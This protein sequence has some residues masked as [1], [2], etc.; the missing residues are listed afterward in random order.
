MSK[1][2]WS[3]VIVMILI[4]YLIFSQLFQ[5]IM[6]TVP[7][8]SVAT[9]TP[10][11]TF[12]PTQVAPPPTIPPAP[13]NTPIPA[14]PTATNTPVIMTEAQQQAATATRSAVET[15]QA[16]PPPPPTETPTPGRPMVTA[17]DTNVNLRAGPGTNY[18]KAGVLRQGESLEIVGRNADSSWWQVSAVDGFK[19]VAAGVTT[20]DN[21][22]SELPLV[23]APPPPATPTPVAPPTATPVPQ[24]Q[25]QYTVFNLFAADSDNPNQGLTRVK[26]VMTDAAGNGVNGISLRIRSGSFCAISSPTHDDGGAGRYDFVLD[27]RARDGSWDLDVVGPLDDWSDANSNKDRCRSLPSLSEKKTV[28]TTLNKSI[29]TL[30]WRKNW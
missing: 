1:R 29:V 23:D 11:A 19:W 6:D 20:A 18:P 13:A 26:G 14:E 28:V 25:F 9:A 17:S 22:V 5:R 2:Q 4:N 3:M 27:N 21:V 16:P 7:V 8:L 12:T 10:I 24:P 30:E 15:E